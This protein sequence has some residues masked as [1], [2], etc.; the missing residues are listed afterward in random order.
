MPSAGEQRPQ[1][2]ASST[3]PCSSSI[4]ARALADG[5]EL[6]LGVQAVGRD[7]VDAGAELLQQR[8]DAHHEELV[9]VGAGDGE[10]LHALE[11]RMRRIV[12]LSEHALVELEPAQLAV[13]VERGVG[14]IRRRRRRTRLDEVGGRWAGGHG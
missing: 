6:L 13:D 10:E 4:C 5:R 12:R 11:Q 7:V 3:S 14:E 9:E 1:Q 2:L 8:R